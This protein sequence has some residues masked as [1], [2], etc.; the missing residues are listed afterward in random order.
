M[1]IICHSQ[2]MFVYSLYLLL[3]TQQITCM[4]QSSAPADH[5]DQKSISELTTMLH[6]HNNLDTVIDTMQKALGGVDDNNG[7]KD[8][9]FTID[10][11]A[12]NGN[13]KSSKL[14]TQDEL[15]NELCK[16]QTQRQNYDAA[17]WFNWREFS[18]KNSN[19][20][21]IRSNF[22]K[23]TTLAYS[24]RCENFTPDT[25]II[26]DLPKSAKA[27]NTSGIINYLQSG[28]S[29]IDPNKK[30]L[31]ETVSSIQSHLSTLFHFFDNPPCCWYSPSER[32]TKL[33]YNV[34]LRTHVIPYCYFIERQKRVKALQITKP[35]PSTETQQRDTQ[36]QY[37]PHAAMI[38]IPAPQGTPPSYNAASYP[39]QLFANPFTTGSASGLPTDKE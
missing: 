8:H 23:T 5:P 39:S 14:Y 31:S 12:H 18:L 24:Q 6:D 33:E 1:K 28:F 30:C 16:I 27:I 10:L 34:F 32:K 26:N 21:I 11:P 9:F 19:K 13:Q 37:P 15:A 7:T 29:T 36:H 38:L 35:M 20:R 22:I 25:S 2:K 17:F 4:Q 3:S